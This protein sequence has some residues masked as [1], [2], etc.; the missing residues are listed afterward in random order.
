MRGSPTTQHDHP[1]AH[2]ISFIHTL[3][4]AVVSLCISYIYC[5]FLASHQEIQLRQ[6]KEQQ[7]PSFHALQYYTH[8]FILYHHEIHSYVHTSLLL[9]SC[10]LFL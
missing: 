5:I 10:L 8:M 1:T 9:Y 7:V 4:V 6:R 3:F 2:C